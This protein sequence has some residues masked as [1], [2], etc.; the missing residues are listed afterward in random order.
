MEE[1]KGLAEAAGARVVDAISQKL[2]SPNPRTGFGKGKVEEIH[3]RL[4]ATGSKLLIVD[5][6]LSP[7]QGRN[8][9]KA[10][11]VRVVDRTEL[12]LD[13]FCTRAN[14]NQAKLQVDLAQQEYMKSRLKRMWTHLERTEGAIGTRGPGETQLETDRRLV[15]KRISDLKKRLSRIA[16]RS[17]RRAVGRLDPHT[18][19]L[20]GY[21]NAGKSTLLTRLSGSQTFVADQ[22][23]AT[24]D[25]KLRYWKLRDKRTLM[26]AD[27]VGFVR[28]LPHH[29]V[30]SFHATLEE[31]IHA[32]L[33]LHVCD[34]S[35]PDLG[36]QMEA[37]ETVLAGLQKKPQPTLLI[38]NKIDLL[39]QNEQMLLRKEFPAAVFVSATDGEGLDE[40]DAVLSATLDRWS[41]HMELRIPVSE[42]KLIADFQ[43]VSKI[44]D[45]HY[46][47][48]FWVAKVTLPPRH[49]AVLN[50]DLQRVGGSFE[51]TQGVAALG[52][53]PEEAS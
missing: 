12:I 11:D 4:T 51:I 27:T 46:H 38:L 30:A 3:R 29:L 52:N 35:A 37:V 14:T 2:A 24:L 49:W 19:S 23:F 1:I 43:M 47:P 18:V 45:A 9:E 26:L 53:L 16:V 32:D 8:L 15:A 20:V 36:L 41:L 17:R 31:T 25:T 50:A 28:D 7:S 5:F 34:A 48:E 39:H 13:I 44:S 33:L 6:D 42:G 40:L 22:L 10:L 21:T